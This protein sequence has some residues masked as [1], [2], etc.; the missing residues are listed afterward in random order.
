MDGATNEAGDAMDGVTEP[1]DSGDD[2]N[3]SGNES[4]APAGDSAGSQDGAGETGGDA[5]GAGQTEQ[6]NGDDNEDSGNTD[7]SDMTEAL[8][9]V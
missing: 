7:A 1:S 4:T 8:P 3:S 2:N 5:T 9:P 6:T